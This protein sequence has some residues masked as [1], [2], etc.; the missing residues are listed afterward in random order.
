MKVAVPVENGVV[1]SVFARAPAFAIYEVNDTGVTLVETVS[2]P[3]INEVRGIG[4]LVVQMLAGAGVE[5]IVAANVG[6]NA[7]EALQAMGMRFYQVAPGVPAE[8]AVKMAIS[9]GAVFRP[10]PPVMDN[11]VGWGYGM[12]R[13]RGFGLGRRRGRGLRWRRGFF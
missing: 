7:F 3:Y 6:P 12:G 2:N 4:P 5:A 1:S 13:G 10:Q 11:L 9:N 8:Q